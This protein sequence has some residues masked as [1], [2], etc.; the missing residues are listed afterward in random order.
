MKNC[1]KVIRVATKIDAI[2]N[3]KAITNEKIGQ[4]LKELKKKNQ[5]LQNLSYK[6]FRKAA[7]Y[8]LILKAMKNNYD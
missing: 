6:S 3:I 1:N 8:K 4:I 7:K 2:L 5:K